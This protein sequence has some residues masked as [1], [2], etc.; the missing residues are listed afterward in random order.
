[1]NPDTRDSVLVLLAQMKGEVNTSMAEIKGKLDEL[2]KD[3]SGLALSI[4]GLE[5]RV[6]SLEG[7]RARVLGALG[8][9]SAIVGLVIA[10]ILAR[11][12][13]DITI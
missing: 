1:M 6:K 13:I 7:W 5:L 2:S 3:V 10:F 11:G 4:A 8:V 9:V 12:H